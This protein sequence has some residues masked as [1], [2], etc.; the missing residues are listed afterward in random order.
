MT[1]YLTVIEALAIH[2]DQI[3]R[4]GGAAD[5]RDPGLLETALYR[6]QTGY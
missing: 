6:P 4:Y 3:R 1:D 5:V 2:G